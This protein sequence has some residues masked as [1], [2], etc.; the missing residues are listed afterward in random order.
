[1]CK[2]KH[3]QLLINYLKY[4]KKMCNL[5]EK[6]NRNSYSLASPKWAIVKY[7]NDDK[8]VHVK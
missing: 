1:M 3:N 2:N 5:F 6:V 4:L 8:F 7:F